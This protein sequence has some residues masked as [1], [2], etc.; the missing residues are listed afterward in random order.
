M[1][2]GVRNYT[3]KCYT[4]NYVTL[5]GIRLRNIKNI[6]NKDTL[7]RKTYIIRTWTPGRKVRVKKVG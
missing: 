6:K 4:Y 2:R 1:R 3:Y 7:K 5:Y